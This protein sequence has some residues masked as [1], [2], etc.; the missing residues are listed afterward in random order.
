M[1]FPQRNDITLKRGGDYMGGSINFHKPAGRWYVQV[2]WQT[3]RYKIW[4]YNGEPIWHEKTADKLLNKIRAEIDEGSF[5]PKTYFPDNP[6]SIR[7]YAKQWL[8]VIDVKPN[9]LKDYS[10][11]VNRFINPFFGE[12]DLRNIRYN[13]IVEFHKWIQRCE[14]GKYNVVSCLRTMLRWAWRSE[15][16]KKVPPFPKL[17]QGELPEIECMTMD[18]QEIVL[19]NIPERHRPI[20]MIGMEYGLRVGELRAIQWDCIKDDEIIIRRAFA[21][22]LLMESTKTNRSRIYGLTPY[23]KQVIKALPMTSSTFVFVRE[24]GKPYTDKNLNAIWSEACKKAGI[25]KVK[26]YNAIRHSLGCQ[27]LDKGFEFDKVQKVLGHTRPEMTKRYA[28]RSNESITQMLIDRRAEI[29]DFRGHLE[30][31]NKNTTS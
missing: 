18:Q 2:Y 17:S 30:V 15:D 14:K 10:Y 4:Q 3:K 19:M 31:K 1:N 23:V 11:S 29:V 12:K 5:Q 27:L 25:K 26:L 6:L 16:I 8:K 9:T 24:D 7:E 21:E 28:K 13:D 20:F 22:N